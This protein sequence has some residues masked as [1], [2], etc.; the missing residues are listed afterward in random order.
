MSLPCVCFIFKEFQRLHS[1]SANPLMASWWRSLPSRWRSWGNTQKKT[2]KQINKKQTK[3]R[4]SGKIRIKFRSIDLLRRAARITF[5]QAPA[6]VSAFE[7]EL[8][9][10]WS[11]KL[12]FS[13]KVS[14]LLYQE[15]NLPGPPRHPWSTRSNSLYDLL[16]LKT[17]WFSES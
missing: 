7:K 15:N 16:N 6:A 10:R 14:S 5:P 2:N 11:I 3:R 8:E 9:Q 4:L 13:R 12:G 1:H 17:L